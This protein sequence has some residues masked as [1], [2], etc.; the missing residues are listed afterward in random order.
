MQAI[1]PIKRG[2]PR[3]NRGNSRGVAPDADTARLF[4]ALWPDEPVRQ[5]LLACPM[6]GSGAAT[7]GGAA[8]HLTVFGSE[9]PR[10]R[11]PRRPR[12]WPVTPF[13]LLL[14]PLAVWPNGVAVWGPPSARGTDPCVSWVA[15]YSSGRAR[16]AALSS[17][18]LARRA[19]DTPAGV[20]PSWPVDHYA[21]VESCP[22]APRAATVLRTGDLRAGPAGDRPL[23]MLGAA[24]PIGTPVISTLLRGIDRLPETG[25][26]ASKS[27]LPADTGACSSPRRTPGLPTLMT[28]LRAAPECL[29][30]GQ[31]VDLPAA[32]PV[33]RW[34]GGIAVQRDQSTTGRGLGRAKAAHGTCS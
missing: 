9:V 23:S 8:S 26:L 20:S 30:D 4:L 6:R 33:M 14:A 29:L 18:A 22:G 27:A 13:E 12:V 11:V 1:R 5:A 32:G 24:S 19:R 34:L 28:R 10:V 31:G 25:Q 21:L 17:H 16:D 3:A 7:P 15:R 2:D